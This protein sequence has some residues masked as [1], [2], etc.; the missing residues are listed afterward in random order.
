MGF[1]K[2]V[3][4]T[5]RVLESETYKDTIKSTERLAQSSYCLLA[6]K[7]PDEAG[8]I[9]SRATELSL[10]IQEIV[11]EEKPLIAALAILTALRVLDQHVQQQVE[12]SRLRR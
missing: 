11:G 8:P 1:F 5:M 3:G 12:D 4:K 9:S 7:S 2:K 6:E 10:K